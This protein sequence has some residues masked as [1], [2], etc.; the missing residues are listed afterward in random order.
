MNSTRMIA[1]LPPGQGSR[2]EYSHLRLT[3]GVAAGYIAGYAGPY[4]FVVLVG[5]FMERFDLTEAGIGSLFGLEMLALASASV[6]FANKG[7]GLNLRRY[8]HIGFGGIVLGYICALL[9]TQL[10]QFAL[11]R[12]IIGLGE[13]LVLGAAN[14]AGATASNSERVFGWAQLAIGSATILLVSTIPPVTLHWDYQAGTGLVLAVLLLTGLFLGL[15]PEHAL[16]EKSDYRRSSPKGLPHLSLGIMV[17]L[18]FLLFSLADLSVWLFAERMGDRAGLSPTTIGLILGAGTGIGLAG[19]VIA[20]LVH[21]RYGRI[22]PFTAGLLLLAGSI[23]GITHAS[24]A[25][26]FIVSLL[27]MNLAVLFLVPYFLGALAEID[28]AGAWTTLS[29]PIVSFGLAVG[30][31]I[32]GVLAAGAGYEAIGWFAGVLVLGTLALMLAALNREVF[33]R[34]RRRE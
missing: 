23:F 16:A 31:I 12:F 26:T 32:T 29:A 21:I 11:A 13:G 15:L 34:T 4:S 2:M 20:I 22:L 28:P 7:I 24:N 5:P 9:S 19:P 18:A 30:P 10:W 1:K 17:L 3:A 27:P 14:S 33:R 6:W 8:S 25:Q